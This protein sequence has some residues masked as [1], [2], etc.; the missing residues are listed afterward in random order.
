M[1]MPST[2][3]KRFPP[4][5]MIR[6][7]DVVPL[8][9]A[10]CGTYGASAEAGGVDVE[11]GEFVQMGSFAAHLVRLLDEGATQDFAAVFGVVELVL[12]HGDAEARSLMSAG[13]LADLTN[14]E[15]YAA[16]RTRPIDFVPWLGALARQERYV[17]ALVEEGY[18]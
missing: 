8:C 17:R 9:T 15:L 16:R 3:V 10:A 5:P 14:L 12:Q 4:D 13:F 7:T 18:P 1:A 2:G 11:D 6:Y